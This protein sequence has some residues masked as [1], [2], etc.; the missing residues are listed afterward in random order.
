[1]RPWLIFTATGCRASTTAPRTWRLRSS[2][3]RAA[4]AE[5]VRTIAAAPH[6]RQDHPAWSPASLGTTAGFAASWNGKASNWRWSRR[7][8]PVCSWSLEAS[9]EELR[10]CS[11]GQRG[12]ALLVE[13][14]YGPLLPSFEEFLLRLTLKGLSVVL[15]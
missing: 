11:Y 6:L 10:L 3:H 8:S 12:R 5:G 1:M 4:S 9:D 15:A 2:W 7:A 14:P 13:T